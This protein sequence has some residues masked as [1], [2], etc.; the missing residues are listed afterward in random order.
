MLADKE[1]PLDLVK[2]MSFGMERKSFPLLQET[3]KSELK[4]YT[5]MLMSEKTLSNSKEVDVLIDMA[6]QLTMSD[7]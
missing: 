4:S 6:S 2:E 3:T 5:S 1:F 7:W